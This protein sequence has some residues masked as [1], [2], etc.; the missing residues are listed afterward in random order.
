MYWV[1]ATLTDN[2]PSEP[3]ASQRRMSY[4]TTVEVLLP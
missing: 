3:K 1:N 2:K 4:V